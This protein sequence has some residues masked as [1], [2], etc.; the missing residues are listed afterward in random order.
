MT[1]A[2]PTLLSRFNEAFVVEQ[3][4]RF[5]EA[6][7]LYR[8]LLADFPQ[9]VG[10][11]DRLGILL[12]AKGD[13]DT[14]LAWFEAALSVQPDFGPAGVNAGITLQTLGRLD[15]AEARFAR[16]VELAPQ[17]A[18]AHYMLSQL[19][20]EKGEYEKACD[21]VGRAIA[22][23]PEFTVDNYDAFY[24]RMT[25]CD[26]RGY[27][28]IT[29]LM[30]RRIRA[31][32]AISSP[33]TFMYYSNSA[34][35]QGRCARSYAAAYYPTQPA[36]WTGQ[37]RKPGKIRLGY[38]SADFYN[39][40]VTMVLAGVYEHHSHEDFEFFAYSLTPPIDHDIRQRVIP[41]FDHFIEAAH[42]SDDQVA[43]LIREHDIDILVS[44][45]G[46]TLNCRPNI[47]AKRPAPVQVSFLGYPGTLGAPYMDYLIADREV[48][49]YEDMRH[50]SEKPVWMPAAYQ[51]TD[52]K[53]VISDVMPT[54]A[55]QG[56]PD[57]AFVFSAYNPTRKIAPAMFDVWMRILERTPGSVLWLQGGGEAAEPNL[58][59]EAEKRGIDPDRLR[60]A[61]WADNRADH[62]ARQKLADLY[63]DTL[64][65]N[66]H[67]IASDHMW[68]GVPVLTCRGGAFAGR[69]C[70]SLLKAAGFPDLVTETLDDYENLAVAL[71]QDPERLASIRRRMETEGHTS[72]L[73]QTEAFTR[74]LEKAYRIMFERQQKGLPPEYIE[75]KA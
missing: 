44:L 54:R 74:H 29:S 53:T 70:A 55:E 11:M 25:E 23:A 56:L 52:D 51:P 10:A 32:G 46:Y 73:F 2:G 4:G 3:S 67:S 42:L 28:A 45:T 31:G 5:D 43:A 50:Y 6:E 61:V 22:L 20:W 18:A 34:A 59:M 69:V 75:V 14:A 24:R 41:S 1:V 58:R 15:E 12:L 7:T 30:T 19:L 60:F 17:F 47:L 8:E 72:P 66:A 21:S 16:T 33:L 38:I 40:A 71:A 48:A 65:Y 27:D 49:P 62:L 64:P 63:I 68:A 57:G 13:A 36:V 39:H 9:V 35:D 26:W 37:P